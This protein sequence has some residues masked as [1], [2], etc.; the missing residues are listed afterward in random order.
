MDQI[1]WFVYFIGE[2]GEKRCH[3]FEHEE[4]QAKHFAKLVN[5]IAELEISGRTILRWEP[6]R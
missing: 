6:K 1:K 5:G 4:N 2:H 3:C